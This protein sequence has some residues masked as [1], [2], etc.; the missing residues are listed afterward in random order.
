[1][2]KRIL[3]PNCG[4]Y[5]LTEKDHDTGNA[6]EADKWACDRLGAMDREPNFLLTYKLGKA[7]Q[8]YLID[9]GVT[10]LSP[11]FDD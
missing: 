7:I 8:Q 5:A 6:D 4:A 11:T 1:M 2:A 9:A 3:C 10:E